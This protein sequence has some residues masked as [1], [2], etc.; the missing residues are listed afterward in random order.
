MRRAAVIVAG[1]RGLRFG[2]ERPKQWLDLLG[3]PL[4]A[5]AAAA[6]AAAGGFERLVLVH[7]P[8][9]EAVAAA[10]IP[11]AILVPGGTERAA[12][13]RAGIEALAADPPEAVLVHDAVRPCVGPA[14]IRSVAA[15]LA[16]C[17]AAAPALPVT[18]ALW[19]GADTVAGTVPRAGLWRAQTP[20]GFRFAPFL[21]AHRAHP[22]G[23]ADDVEVARAAGLA[24]AI[25]PGD[26]DNIKV[27]HPGDLAR[28]ARILEGRMEVRT[29]QGLDVHAFG[30]GSQL[31]L[32]G[33]RISH[34]Q[35]VVAH[36]DGDVGLHALTDAL[37]GALA[38]GDIG[39]HFPPSDPRWRGADSRL[40]LRHAAALA[41]ARGY[42]IGN[43]DVTL[44]CEAP[45][46]APHV[47]AMR[48]ATAEALGIG[49]DRV[50]IK[51]TTS[52]RLGFAG[53]GE[54]IAALAVATLLR[55]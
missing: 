29:G 25:L 15:A 10:A 33:V 12:S 20:Q 5:H 51:A 50:G 32:C 54:G 39:R 30:P 13:V 23:A 44:V 8:G 26:E 28:A 37:L 2:A 14:L 4:A 52:E 21:A 48:A 46:I 6:F 35:G 45:R 9:D 55:P 36:S 18:D 27:T 19:R 1:G 43:V 22:G 40:F 47:E 49:P 16:G 11:G 3:R 31:V 7:P 24:V 42:R 53:R 41:A 34:S 38:E 17:D